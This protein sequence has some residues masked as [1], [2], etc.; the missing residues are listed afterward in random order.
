MTEAHST[1]PSDQP[2]ASPPRWKFAVIVL[3]A[4]YPLLLV[5]L[6]TLGA[7]F[8]DV[9]YLAV[10][11][12]IGPEL[13]VRTFVTAAILVNLMIWVA[14]PIL[15]GIFGSWLSRAGRQGSVE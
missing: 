8:G 7:A 10:P 13:F 6:P 4:I 2:P 14:I 15:T 1:G 5:V 11:I 9:P 3:M 12:E